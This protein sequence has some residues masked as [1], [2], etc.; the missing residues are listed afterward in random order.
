MM[1][2][3]VADATG[4]DLRAI[5]DYDLDLAFGADENDFELTCD[6]RW[7][8]PAGGYVYADGTEYGG[9]VDSVRA[10]TSR[11]GGRVV[12]CSGRTWHGILAGKRLVSD[13][14]KSHLRASGPAQAALRSLV[15]RMGLG[16]LFAA[17]DDAGSGTVD[18]EFERF[19]DAYSG[20]RAMLAASGLKLSLTCVGGRVV[21][22]ALPVTD[23][24]TR[25]DSDQIDFSIT[26]TPRRTNHL[27]C[28]GEGEMEDR[29]VLHLYADEKGRVSR[30]QSLFGVDEIA[31]LY[32]YSN[33]DESKLL[34]D[35]TKRLSE[36]QGEGS[37]EVE[38][39][40]DLEMDVG[41]VVSGRDWQTGEVVTAEVTKKILSVTA[42]EPTVTYE[43]G[44]ATTGT[45]GSSQSGSAESSGGASYAAGKGIS[46][47][48]RTI[49]AEVDL[50]DL[51][52][53][54][55]VAREAYSTASA[56]SGAASGRVRSV[57]GSGAV[58]A[59]TD[60]G[61]NVTVSVRPATG[62]EDGLMSPSDKEKLDG[63][64][65]GANRYVL[66]AATPSSL[67]GV[68]PDGTSVTVDDDGTLHAAPT[69]SPSVLAAHPV[70]TYLMVDSV[71][72][73][74][75]AAAFGGAWEEAPSVGPGTWLRVG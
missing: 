59:S 26:R 70:G 23:W 43:V 10:E 12:T 28:C 34:E 2:L 42:G 68:R 32:D 15:S 48:G 49:S 73:P 74:D 40:D 33:A 19:C 31:A 69:S 64:E 14:G 36:L 51:A 9:T 44:T 50:Q 71:T 63:V 72:V 62:E 60:E 45:S 65:S 57:S 16:P 3:I 22:G 11:S 29:T 46:I 1:E 35:G 52:E 54:E 75:P 17:P 20:I 66:P 30:T 21:M 8:P 37:I 18:Y 61:M 39:H 6:P 67:G 24:S 47:V 58:T 27:V 4:R 13:A 38:A 25:V 55:D 53:V 41:D 7:A 5:V 56:A